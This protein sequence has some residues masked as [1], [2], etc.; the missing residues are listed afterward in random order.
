MTEPSDTRDE[1]ER[2]ITDVTHLGHMSRI[3]EDLNEGAMFGDQSTFKRAFPN[4]AGGYIV[5]T[6]EDRELLAFAASD[7]ERR[8][9]DLD[10]KVGMLFHRL[11][12]AKAI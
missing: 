7:I 5:V 10:T 2:L 3:L 4:L 6:L 9:R 1:F 8:C 12:E 11:C